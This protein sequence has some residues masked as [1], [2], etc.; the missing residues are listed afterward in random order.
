MV[1]QV[2][3]HTADLRLK[4]S[5]KNKEG[6]LKE[7][8]KGMMSI[9]KEK[10]SEKKEISKEIKIESPDLV[11]L[12]VDFLNEALYNACA[13]KAIFSAVKFEFFSDTKLKA[14]IFGYKI[15]DG[16]DKD[17]KAATYYKAEIK[18]ING[19]YEVILVFD[20]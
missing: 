19:N 16:F 17:I 8:L 2:L 20:I 14:K 11:S 12:L 15:E 5:A 4:I 1:Y 10:P 9:L 6:L 18:E 13:N 7:A 3:G